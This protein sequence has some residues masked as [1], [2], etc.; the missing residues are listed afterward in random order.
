MTVIKVSRYVLPLAVASA[1]LTMTACAQ[2]PVPVQVQPAGAATTQVPADAPTTGVTIAPPTPSATRPGEPAPTE[3]KTEQVTGPVA[4]LEV[5]T[6]A[7]GIIV[8]GSDDPGV[9]VVRRI[10]SVPVAPVETV[11]H[12]GDLLHIESQCPQDN[13]PTA[14]CRIDYEITLPRE[15]QVTLV[16]ASGDLNTSGLVGPLAAR[17]ASGSV[18]LDQ[19]RSADTIAESTS[20]DVQVHLLDR[21]QSLAATS[22]SGD[23]QVRVPDAGPYR[24]DADTVSGDAEVGVRSDP[25][26]RSVLRLRTTSGDVSVSTG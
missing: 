22:V 5:S 12:D 8:H 17:T 19:H 24:V 14:P 18:E 11:R 6:A 2:Q 20:G 10:Y 21:P 26:A 23:V 15:T 3:V 1:A 7:G 13:T 16:A 9:T 25:A 4:R